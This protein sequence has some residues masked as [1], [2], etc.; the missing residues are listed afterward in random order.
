MCDVI[1]YNLIRKIFFDVKQQYE[2]RR[3]TSG[4]ESN[5]QYFVIGYSLE[6]CYKEYPF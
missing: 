6:N 1:I 3:E 4:Q 5:F 2:N